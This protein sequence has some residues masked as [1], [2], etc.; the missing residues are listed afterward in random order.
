M[1][2]MREWKWKFLPTILL[3]IKFFSILTAWSLI[4]L[5]RYAL[6]SFSTLYLFLSFAASFLSLSFPWKYWDGSTPALCNTVIC[7]IRSS[8]I[9]ILGP[10]HKYRPWNKA[11]ICF[12]HAFTSTNL[13]KCGIWI[14]EIS[15]DHYNPNAHYASSLVIGPPFPCAISTYVSLGNF[16]Y[17]IIFLSLY[18]NFCNRYT[19]FPMTWTPFGVV[20]ILMVYLALFPSHIAGT[21][22]FLGDT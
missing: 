5:I 22:S 13:L 20:G 16:G 19:M 12:T 2:T 18:C 7:E 15:P 1:W 4:V 3:V 11:S 10:N 17:G 9:K 8:V 14:I 21:P 6:V